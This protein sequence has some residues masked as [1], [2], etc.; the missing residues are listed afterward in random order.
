MKYNI[1]TVLS[2][3][4]YS[5]PEEEEEEKEEA[6]HHQ[7]K[8]MFGSLFIIEWEWFSFL[9]GTIPAF[10]GVKKGHKKQNQVILKQLFQNRPFYQTHF[11][12]IIPIFNDSRYQ[13]GPRLGHLSGLMVWW[14]KSKSLIW[15]DTTMSQAIPLGCF[16]AR[17]C[18][19]ESWFPLFK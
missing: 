18:R 5:L 16:R 17:I 2:C 6:Y 14:T 8:G 9:V 11:L 1:Q 15:W 7:T 19:P 4:L 13:M 10:E 12:R 3:K